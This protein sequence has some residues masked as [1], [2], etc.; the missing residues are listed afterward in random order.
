MSS[1]NIFRNTDPMPSEQDQQFININQTQADSRGAPLS[2]AVKFPNDVQNTRG[3]M[4]NP[5][6]RRP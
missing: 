3:G 5:T 2:G 1:T 4:P 6:G